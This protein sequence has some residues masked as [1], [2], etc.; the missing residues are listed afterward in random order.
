M[1]CRS[2]LISFSLVML[3]NVSFDWNGLIN[4][5]YINPSKEGHHHENI[6]INSSHI[7]WKSVP[8]YPACQVLD[9]QKYLDSRDNPLLITF[10]FNPIPNIGIK[11]YL[12]EKNKIH[13]RTMKQNALS[14]FGP[15][16]KN[17]NLEKIKYIK[18]II[19]I[20]QRENLENYDKKQCK[21]YPAD[22]FE[23]YNDCDKVYMKKII[24]NKFNI[25]PFW[26]A[27]NL[28]EITQKL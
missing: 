27:E 26:M 1:R 4:S 12:E 15:E 9:F 24:K 20:V 3:N 25:T 13:H 18:A 14:Y 10:D 16:L 8:L 23:T 21:N 17:I 7:D 28:E 6:E 5:I 19:K 2:F 11:I 22:N